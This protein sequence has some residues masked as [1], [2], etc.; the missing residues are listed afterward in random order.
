[1]FD[2]ASTRID[3]ITVMERSAPNLSLIPEV[4]TIIFVAPVINEEPSI[5]DPTPA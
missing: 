5:L 1:M 3:P 2:L 4:D